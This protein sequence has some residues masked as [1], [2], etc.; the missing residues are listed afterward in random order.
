VP[1]PG[2]D[3][4]WTCVFGTVQV[5]VRRHGVGG[6]DDVARSHVGPIPVKPMPDMKSRSGNAITWFA[7]A[8]ADMAASTT[9]PKAP[10][11]RTE[12]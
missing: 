2:F 10:G 3:T 11:S 7:E 1:G 4:R 8:M 9:R 12:K 5:S 6:G